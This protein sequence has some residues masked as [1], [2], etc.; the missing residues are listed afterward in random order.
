MDGNSIKD[1]KIIDR[2]LPEVF[3]S[4]MKLSRLDILNLIWMLNTLGADYLEINLDILKKVEKLPPNLNFIYR[5]YS[6][7]DLEGLALH[8]FNNILLSSDVPQFRSI[9]DSLTL[10]QKDITI[11]FR[12]ET[13]KQLDNLGRLFEA[14]FMKGV[15]T[16]R[17]IGLNRFVTNEWL[18]ICGRIKTR[19]GVSIDICPENRFY[20]ATAAAVDGI[21]EAA[22]FVTASFT[23]YGGVS[24]YAAIEQVLTFIKVILNPSHR[25]QL[26][27]LP[28][29]SR[30]F[31]KAAGVKI[32]ENMPVIGENIFK[33]ESGIHADGINKNPMTYEPYDP[34]IVG[35]ERKLSIGKHSG[36]KSAL[37]K[38]QELGFEAENVQISMFLKLLREKSILLNRNLED[39]EIM[40]LAKLA[41]VS[42]VYN[43]VIMNPAKS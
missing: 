14:G 39:N 1:K 36:R 16:V 18:D 15:R 21:M 17:I 25:I 28:E 41:E 23:G 5:I 42:N 4:N 8:S 37:K 35:Q 24:G 40:D 38:L 32:P 13:I 2:T 30:S 26:K 29:M 6:W 9:L 12:V 22:D 7:T 27:A 33:Y 20:N 31:S 34:Q 19:Y 11:E 10:Y 43:A 3:F